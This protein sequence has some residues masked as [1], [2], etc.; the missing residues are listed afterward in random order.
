MLRTIED[1]KQKYWFKLDNAA[2]IYPAANTRRWS[3]MFRL[4]VTLKEK[5]DSFILQEALAVTIKRF[6]SF[7][8]RMRKGLFWYYFETNAKKRPIVKPDINNPCAPI[9]WQDNNGFLLRVFYY[10][11]RIAIDYFHSLTDGTGAMVFLKTLTAQYLHLK[12][13]EIPA[14][15]GVLDVNE[16]PDSEEIEDSFGRYANSKQRGRASEPKAYHMKSTKLDDKDISIIAGITSLDK[17]KQ[18]AKKNNSTITEYLAALLLYSFYKQKE[19]EGLY[20][21]PTRIAVSIPVNLR[22][23]FKS[24]TK[25]NF[26]LFLNPGIDTILG[27]FTFEEI[28]K[29]IQYF[30][31]ANLNQKTLNAMMTQNVITERNILIRI[32]PLFIK[33]FLMS[34]AHS[35]IGYRPIS[36]LLSNVGSVTLPCEM[37]EHIDRFEFILGAAKIHTPYLAVVSYNDTL[38]LNFTSK[39]KE[40]DIER[41]FF[42]YLIK[43]GIPVKIESNRE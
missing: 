17:I 36:T 10:D 32:A 11:K 14:K 37:Q 27:E 16:Q 8:I 35:T 29:Q 22:N 33:N 26:S 30:M 43:K 20:V 42:T 3:G 31:K 34:I 2:K 7:N 6:P 28:L 1:K 24:N 5:V 21:K 15:D 41:Y 13:Y 25:R 12:G 39:I 9:K 19:K 23:Y 40:T 4:S 38:V 18:L